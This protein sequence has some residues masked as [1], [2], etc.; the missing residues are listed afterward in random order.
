[1]AYSVDAREMAMNYLKNGHTI[2]EAHSELKVGITTL[3]CWKTRLSSGGNLEKAPLERKPRIFHDNELREYIAQNPFATLNEIAGHFGGSISGA[4]H[5]LN[6]LKITL[7]KGLQ[8]IPRETK[9]NERS[10]A[11]NLFL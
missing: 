5:A 8:I 3:R 6:R 10:S 2:S 9:L 1:M 4:F 7:K 11:P